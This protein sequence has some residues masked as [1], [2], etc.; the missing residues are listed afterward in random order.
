MARLIILGGGISG[1]TAALHAKSQLGKKHEVVVITPNS[2]YN[3]IP[4][5][6]WVGVGAM[7]KN[8]VL[9]P[10]APIYKKKDIKFVQGRATS[11]HPEGEGSNSIPF[12]SYERT[13]SEGKGGVEK[14]TYDYLIN[15]TGPKLNF[16]A[17]PGLGPDNGHTLS[18]CTADH[19]GETWERLEKLIHQMKNGEK[20]KIVIGTG[21]GTCTCQGA[22]FEYILNLEFKLRQEKVRDMAEI[23]WIS[24]EAELGDLGMGGMHIKRGGYI[25]HSKIFTESVFAERGI[26]WV[27]QS[28]VKQV[29][30]NKIHAVN[31]RGEEF[32]MDYDFAMLLPP[33]RGQEIKAIDR[34]GQDISNQVFAANGFMMVD[35]DY[36]P[37]PYEAWTPTDWPKTYQSQKFPNL[38]A[39]GIAFAP[40]HAISKPA[41]TADGIPIFPAPPRTGMPSGVMAREVA[42]NIADLIKGKIKTPK[43][44]ASMANMGAACI[45]SA[46]SN[47]F[48]GTAVAMTMYPIVADFKKYPNV[49]R[50]LT[51]T[52]GEIGLAGHW[53]KY[54]L[55]IIF[56]YKA[57]AK[58]LW[59]LIPE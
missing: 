46:G 49:G 14:M 39:V 8:Q 53:I 5:N 28:H 32:E 54:I 26:R 58:F 25:T 55:H 56:I 3:W 15:A 52:T 6:I 34:Q 20:K 7:K 9:F 21:H 24:N 13:D 27:T 11:I 29:E 17:T 22:A 59:K 43:R 57:K 48:N 38:F 16:A 18:V 2:N 1:H 51:Y 44:T 12:V 41:K 31:L 30:K 45:A 40:P 33:F 4:S 36:T 35:A 23:S 10:L 37:K 42:L 47:F 19:A 50:S